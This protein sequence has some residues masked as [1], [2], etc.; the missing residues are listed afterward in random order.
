MHPKHLTIL[1]VKE[2]LQKYCETVYSR[3]GGFRGGQGAR[4]PRF[5]GK[6]GKKVAYIGNH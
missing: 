3:R 2:G 1:Q 6:F 4:A 5:G